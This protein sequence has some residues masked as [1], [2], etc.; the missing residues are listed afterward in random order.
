[1]SKAVKWTACMVAVATASFA[2][3][4]EGAVGEWNVKMDY[5]G[6]PIE[7]KM[8]IKAGD[9][10]AL[11][12]LWTSARGESALENIKFENG[13]LTFTRKVNA[14]GQ[15]FELTFDGTIEGDTV[16]GAYD[17]PMGALAVEGTRP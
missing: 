2:F 4:A 16:K 15:E 14:Q 12:G 8:L 5:Q 1:M 17:S 6:N 7:A 9:D 3:A 10:G 11:T 13:K